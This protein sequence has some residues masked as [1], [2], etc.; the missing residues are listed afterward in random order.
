M[1]IIALVYGGDSVESDISVIT[2]KKIRSKLILEGREVLDIF[3]DRNGSFYINDRNKI[4]LGH[5][6]KIGESSYFRTRFKYFEFDVVLPLV[7]GAGV[8]DGTLGAFFDTLKIPC[9][10]SGVLNS[11][12]L[13][14]KSF[15]KKILNCYDI[16][17]TKYVDLKYERF[18]DINFDLKKHIEELNFPLIIKPNTLGSSIGVKKAYDYDGLLNALDEA[19]VY[20][21]EIVIEECVEN[22]KEVNIAVLGYKDNMIFSELETVS[23]KDEV[24]TFFD[25]YL[26]SKD[27]TTRIIPSDISIDIKNIIL[28]ITKKTFYNLDCFGVVRF[29]YL[30]DEINHKIY[31]N[32]INTIPGSLAYYLF[33]PLNITVNQICDIMYENY[34]KKCKY[35]NRIKHN[36]EEGNR[37]DLLSKE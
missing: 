22:L 25:K 6:E 14:N 26:L 28:E 2:Y 23:N 12:I 24:L 5:F 17:N 15:F 10:Y 37:K 36:Y 7:H 27:K 3:L 8:E 20:D 30:I 9:M 32:E 13:Q 4:K 34:S 33:E 35:Y 18:I 29:D 11:A 19:F 21:N 1:K 31:L 16:P